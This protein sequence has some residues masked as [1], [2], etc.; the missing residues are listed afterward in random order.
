MNSVASKCP[1]CDKQTNLTN[2][3][4][5]TDACGHQKC[6]QCIIIQEVNGCIQCEKVPPDVRSITIQ[7]PTPSNEPTVIDCN[8]TPLRINTAIPDANS[9]DSIKSEHT[10]NLNEKRQKEQTS[11]R[12]RFIV[13]NY[14]L[15]HSIQNDEK[16]ITEVIYECTKCNRKFRS[17]NQRRYHSFCDENM[18]KPHKCDECPRGFKKATHLEYHKQLHS[19]QGLFECNDCD[20]KFTHENSLKK[21]KRLHNLNNYKFA[22]DKCNKKFLDRN[23]LIVHQNRHNNVLP[24]KC[25]S[26]DKSFL[27][28]GNLDKH[29]ITHS[30]GVRNFVCKLC[31]RKFTRKQALQ[32]HSDSHNKDKV[33]CTECHKKFSNIKTLQRHLQTHKG[34]SKS[35]ECTLCDTSSYRKDNLLRHARNFHPNE[36]ASQIIKI[37]EILESDNTN[38]ISTEKELITD[39]V[40]ASSTC[41][42]ETVIKKTEV[43][44]VIE[45]GEDKTPAPQV[46]ESNRVNVIQS[47]GNVKPVR[48]LY[49]HNKTLKLDEIQ[50]NSSP[51]KEKE[52]RLEQFE[53]STGSSFNRNNI[54][55][56]YDPIEL[57]RKI[58]LPSKEDDDVNITHVQPQ[59]RPQQQAKRE[60][61]K[62]SNATATTASQIHWRKR[63]SQYFLDK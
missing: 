45:I 34:R 8:L 23:Q 37:T 33:V 55:K 58:L 21:H 25:T 43:T 39:D 5:I 18:D 12:K 6:R 32:M 22:C 40:S 15:T 4:L 56:A 51:E 7:P 29:Q 24:F 9:L 49:K 54:T 16:N 13:P 46:I 53:F 35:Y 3:R 62:T 17:K 38:S 50:N 27:W 2:H 42:D 1:E 57:Y 19:N 28:K 41:L 14:I 44:Q 48:L 52:V 36:I 47:I 60:S 31:P 20:K 59:P 30:G 26:C 61:D 63:R 11:N 10:G